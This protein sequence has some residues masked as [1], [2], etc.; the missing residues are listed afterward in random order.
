MTTF[1]PPLTTEAPED[2]DAEGCQ[3]IIRS[4][5]L[6]ADGEPGT[7]TAESAR[8]FETEGF[9][10]RWAS[11]KGLNPQDAASI[12]FMRDGNFVAREYVKLK[13][14]GRVPRYF[15]IGGEVYARFVWG[16][17]SPPEFATA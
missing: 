1:A 6:L 10:E 8:T 7:V 2:F 11:S 9:I 13:P 5:R 12:T 16:R 15:D 17:W 3:R 14:K 4:L